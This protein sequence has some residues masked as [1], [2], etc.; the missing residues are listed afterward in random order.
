[1]QI[2][3]SRA[4]L[5]R[6]IGGES[7]IEVALRHQV[8]ENFAKERIKAFINSDLLN[9][10]HAEWKRE[11]SCLI[12]VKIKEFMITAQS[13]SD[14]SDLRRVVL[15]LVTKL[16]QT[17]SEGILEKV[18]SERIE[19]IALYER[20]ALATVNNKIESAIR[21]VDTKI[22]KKMNEAFERRVDAEVKRRLELAASIKVEHAESGD[23]PSQRGIDV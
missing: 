14:P 17:M 2:L 11:W 20:R 21:E 1:M 18:A 3:L 16:V 19:S 5:E 7:E 15:D 12:D 6:L 9:K 4:A 23:T 10:L 22:E 8:V 13:A